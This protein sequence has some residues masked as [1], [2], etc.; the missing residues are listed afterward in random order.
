VPDDALETEIAA[1]DMLSDAGMHDQSIEHFRAL[2]ARLPREPR[3]QFALASALEAAD[4]AAEAVPIYAAA[5][6]LRPTG[7]LLARTYLGLGGA[8][9]SLERYQEALEVLSA[10]SR[11]F[12]EHAPLRAFL[13]LATADTGKPRETVVLLVEDLLEHHDMGAYTEPLRRALAQLQ[14]ARRR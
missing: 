10:G 6:K 5:I 12:P 9:R 13:A 7:E 4:R 8:L 1:G 14:R 11:R 3:V 2:S